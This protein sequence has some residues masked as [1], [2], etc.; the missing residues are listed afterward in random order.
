MAH[1]SH[2]YPHVVK[3]ERLALRR[4]RDREERGVK[5]AKFATDEC[6][7]QVQL[8][9]DWP[10]RLSRKAYKQLRDAARMER[11]LREKAKK[12]Q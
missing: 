7:K 4:V 10:V 6:I 12:S 1:S 8:E 3:D 9:S 2:G 5:R 11:F